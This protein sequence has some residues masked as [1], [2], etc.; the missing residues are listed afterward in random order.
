MGLGSA[1][2]RV[3]QLWLGDPGIPAN[4][5][6]GRNVYIGPGVVLDW[7]FG[8]LIT[9]GDEATVVSGT[10]ILCHDASSNRRLGV[11]WCAPV[12]I[13]ARAYV[14]AD[15]LIL[16]GVSIGDDAV[17]AAGAV[18]TRDVESGTVV[19]GIPAEQIS[20]T[21]ELD[22]KRRTL[23]QSRPIYGA[24]FHGSALPRDRVDILV[25]AGRAGYFL[26]SDK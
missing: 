19:A 13:G 10:R 7:S 3:R 11:T 26:Q 23:M 9:I 21:A 8:H 24:D 16:P 4:I 2:L 18:V 12:V 17:V 14:G 5:T 1:L 6:I 25:Q 22:R 15:A 20:T